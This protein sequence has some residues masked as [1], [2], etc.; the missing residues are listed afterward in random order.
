YGLAGNPNLKWEVTTQFDAGLESGLLND[1]LSVE[2]DYYHK[3]TDSILIA[4]STPGYFGNGQGGLITFNAGSVLNTGVE[5]SVGWR[6]QI[7]KVKYN[8]GV[9][10]S[11]IHNEVIQVGGSSGVDSVLI[12]GAIGNGQ[13]V[14]LSKKGFPIGAFYGYKTDG[15]FQNQA[16]LDAYPH[17]SDAEIGFLK[18]VDV[19]GD[20]VIDD[21]D[22]TYLGSPIP[23]FIFGFNA[24]VE[25]FGLDFSVNIQGQ[26]GNTIFN[27]KEIVRPDKYNFESHVLNGWTS[28]GSTNT[29]PRPTWG[30]YNFLPSDKYVQDGSYLRIRSV[31]LGYSLPAELVKKILMTKIRV[32][33]KAENL[34]TFTKYTGYSPEISSGSPIYNGL[35][36]GGYPVT[37]VYSVG[38]NINF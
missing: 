24:G 8:I 33:L 5:F 22:R 6:D 7:G 27:V 34:Y 35:D 36:F 12:G 28:D 21:R 3:T 29:E 30:G 37:S 2:F 32:Y 10:G 19:N 18:F 23:T 15:I 1:R 38:I 16:D 25:L 20:G 14:T 31:V 9:N 13:T 17:R 26:T 11:T 4:L